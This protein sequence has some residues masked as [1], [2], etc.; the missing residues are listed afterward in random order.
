MTIDL[1]H[2][3]ILTTVNPLINMAHLYSKFCL[4]YFFV[5]DHKHCLQKLNNTLSEAET[6]S[7]LTHHLFG[8]LV[9][10]SKYMIDGRHRHEKKCFACKE[11]I[12]LG[13]TSIGKSI[14]I[15]LQTNFCFYYTL[16]QL[17]LVDVLLS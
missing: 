14:C 17:S 8:P 13:N 3:W 4:F 12:V 11:N 16:V 15:R 7:I 10:S 6:Q 1:H 2:R 5:D 9:P